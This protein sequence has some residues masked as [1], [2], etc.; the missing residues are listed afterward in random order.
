[1]NLRNW[2]AGLAIAISVFVIVM[3]PH[4]L[5]LDIF[6]DSLAAFNIYSMI[7]IIRRAS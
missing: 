1:M 6:V 5:G 7:K 2:F 3:P 4:S